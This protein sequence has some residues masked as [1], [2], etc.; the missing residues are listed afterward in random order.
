MELIEIIYAG[1][2]AVR[3][4]NRVRLSEEE[5]AQLTKLTTTG[6]AAA[7]TRTHAEILLAA[8]AGAGDSARPDTEIAARVRVG[9]RTVE[10]VRQ[11]YVEEG[12]DAALTP[13]PRHNQHARKVDGDAEAHLIAL[14]CRTPPEGQARWTLRLLAAEVAA[15]DVGIAVSHETVRRVLKK[16]R[17]EAVAGEGVVHPPGREW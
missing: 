13:R 2:S 4:K 12:L 14:A 17:V 10:R 15:L 16:K 11:R 8:D 3:R 6:R 9:V 1:A 5:R 7:R